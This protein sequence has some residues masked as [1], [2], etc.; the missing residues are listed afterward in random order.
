MQITGEFKRIIEAIEPGF[1]VVIEIGVQGSIPGTAKVTTTCRR[2]SR[3]NRE[4]NG[5]RTSTAA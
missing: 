5:N 4:D 1:F 2:T 3:E